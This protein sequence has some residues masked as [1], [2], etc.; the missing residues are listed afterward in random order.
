MQWTSILA[1]YALVWVMTAF[2]MLPFGVKTHD[3]AGVPKVP[4]QA[5]SAPANFRPRVLVFRASVIAAVLTALYI[6]NY[7]FGWIGV[8]DLNFL[9]PLFLD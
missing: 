8:E 1:I 6:A 9:G 3:E 4:G 5:D 7:T 2:V